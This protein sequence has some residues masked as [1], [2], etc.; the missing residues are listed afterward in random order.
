MKIT[1]NNPIDAHLLSSPSIGS[2]KNVASVPPRTASPTLIQNN[3]S[4]FCCTSLLSVSLIG[5]SA[6]C[7]SFV[8]S[9]ESGFF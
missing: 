8:K 3:M 5:G 7:G 1:T 2:N 9:L 4:I 6:T